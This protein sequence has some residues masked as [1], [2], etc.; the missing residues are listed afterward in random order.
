MENNY[1]TIEFIQQHVD[2]MSSYKRDINVKI[3]QLE[4]CNNSERRQQLFYIELKVFSY[5]NPYTIC[6]KS[7]SCQANCIS[8]VLNCFHF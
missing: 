6:A 8:S 5:F 4:I 1:D 2:F 3:F 7:F